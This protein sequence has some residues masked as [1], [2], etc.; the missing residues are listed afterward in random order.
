[1]VPKSSAVLGYGRET[2]LESNEDHS[3]IA[4]LFKSESNVYYD[5]QR[6]IVTAV[7]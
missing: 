7:R 2:V 5:V 4:K 1:M 3:G 6:T